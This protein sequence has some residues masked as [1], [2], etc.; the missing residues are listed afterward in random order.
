MNL[1]ELLLFGENERREI[2]SF[3]SDFTEETSSLAEDITNALMEASEDEDFRVVIQM[4]LNK[5]S[6]ITKYELEVN[7]IHLID[8]I[9]KF[10]DAYP[11][12][13][14]TGIII[15]VYLLW[16]EKTEPDLR[17]ICF[18]ITDLCHA[19]PCVADGIE[20]CYEA[21]LFDDGW[22]FISRELS[23]ENADGEKIEKSVKIYDTW[24]ILLHNPMLFTALAFDFKTGTR[25]VLSEKDEA[26]II[27]APVGEE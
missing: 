13:E 26:Y 23:L 2:K 5:T 9:E 18:F 11:D 4:W 8:M 15:S 10:C 27:Y 21:E 19:E 20:L 17:G 12:Q 3:L 25:L 14:R 6:D 22:W 7:G 16:L 24:Q 1:T